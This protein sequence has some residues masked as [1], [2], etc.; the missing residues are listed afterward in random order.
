[1]CTVANL[2]PPADAR[3]GSR[4]TT[5]L[6]GTRSTSTGFVAV[7]ATGALAAVVAGAAKLVAR[8]YVT[9]T[10][11]ATAGAWRCGR[12]RG[13]VG[14]R[15]RQHTNQD[16]QSHYHSNLAN[17]D[18][19]LVLEFQSGRNNC[20]L[21][22]GLI[23]PHTEHGKTRVVRGHWHA[24]R[25]RENGTRPDARRGSPLNRAEQRSARGRL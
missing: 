2:P 25:V 4:Q 3:G 16:E 12:A 22:G 7:G 5:S 18:D 10:C 21:R 23:E 9:A 6:R 11:I 15:K 24:E 20:L 14:Y 17:H 1:M 19:L 8:A 13:R